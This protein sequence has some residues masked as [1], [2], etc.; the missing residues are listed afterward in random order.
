MVFLHGEVVLQPLPVVVVLAVVV[1][2]LL[3]VQVPLAVVVDGLG[4]KIMVYV[5]VVGVEICTGPEINVCKRD[6]HYP[7]RSG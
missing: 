7:S 4:V 1:L 2:P 3:V 5:R 6:K